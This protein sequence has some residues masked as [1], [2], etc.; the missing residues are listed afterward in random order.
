MGTRTFAVMSV[1]EDTFTEIYEHLQ[2]AGYEHAI[3]PG[4]VEGTTLLD[5][6][7]IALAKEAPDTEDLPSEEEPDWSSYP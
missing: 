2:R 1:S 5:M 3:L 4:E 6:N 7:G